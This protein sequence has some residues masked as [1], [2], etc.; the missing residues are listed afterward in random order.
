M[1]KLF[2]ILLLS[3]VFNTTSIAKDYT[4]IWECKDPYSNGEED[5]FGNSK[6]PKVI[7]TAKIISPNSG[8]L[9]VAGVT[10]RSFYSV[11][12]FN[13]RWDF[14]SESDKYGFIIKPNGDGFYY[15]F[16]D[17]KSTKAT[18]V[19]ECWQK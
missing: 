5:F 3:I 11:Q 2:T 1:K 19:L 8:E 18:L 10:Q 7:F 15:K 6:P 12:G 17:D 14:G 4:E 9:D 16:E 13:R